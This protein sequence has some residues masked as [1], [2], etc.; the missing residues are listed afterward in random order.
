MPSCAHVIMRLHCDELCCAA[1]G[2]K[3]TTSS[4]AWRPAERERPLR[5]CSGPRQRAAPPRDS[6]PPHGQPAE[7]AASDT[8]TTRPGCA[9][10]LRAPLLVAAPL[11]TR[12]PAAL[13]EAGL[14]C[15]RHRVRRPWLAGG[16]ADHSALLH[17]AVPA[18]RPLPPPPPAG[19]ITC[20]AP[21][22]ASARTRPW[23]PASSPT[24]S[25]AVSLPAPRRC[26]CT[27][28]CCPLMLSRLA[29]APFDATAA[30]R[31]SAMTRRSPHTDTSLMATSRASVRIHIP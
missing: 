14:D 19:C 24:A 16:A 10:P 27:I 23:A 1:A 25:A 2:L 29:A 12:S 15:R 3:S 28:R 4:T 11:N 6:L 30:K 20:P 21:T 13:A 5:P 17:G 31:R 26:V 7:R 9:C 8:A 18:E 22:V